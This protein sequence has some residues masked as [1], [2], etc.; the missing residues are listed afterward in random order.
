M[1]EQ[2]QRKSTLVSDAGTLYCSDFTIDLT[3]IV[4][5]NRDMTTYPNKIEVEVLAAAI[6]RKVYIYSTLIFLK[7]RLIFNI[8]S[9]GVIEKI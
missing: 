3:L 1:S 7:V 2:A 6:G 8:I 5:G 4:A 9:H